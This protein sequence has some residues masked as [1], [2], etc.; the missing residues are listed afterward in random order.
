[1]MATGGEV[2]GS[3]VGEIDLLAGM[4]N[5]GFWFCC[6]WKYLRFILAGKAAQSCQGRW[7]MVPGA[8]YRFGLLE[9]A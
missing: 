9:G 1:M 2:F 8:G 6:G 4:E 5:R 3:C 7:M